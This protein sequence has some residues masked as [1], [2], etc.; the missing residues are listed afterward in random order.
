MK[1]LII[2]NKS[3]Y[4]QELA[5]LFPNVV[6]LDK[7]NLTKNFDTTAYNLIVLSGG[8]NVPTVLRHPE[9]YNIEIE[10]IKNTNVPI[11]GICLGAEIITKAFD[12]EL[13]ELPKEHRGIVNLGITHPDLE[14]I[15]GTQHLE[16]TEGHH[17]GI[18]TLPKDFI[19]CAESEHGVE[20]I[21]H[22]N[23]PIIGVQFHPEISNNKVIVQWLVDEVIKSSEVLNSETSQKY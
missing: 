18:K 19:S 13:Q 15:L 5:S 1:T 4:I 14:K 23:K 8:S 16:V 9:E 20:I 22:K 21:K 11:I 17:I 6:V 2:N 12:G 3:K 10:L 7:E